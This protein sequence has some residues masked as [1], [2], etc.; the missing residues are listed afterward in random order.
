LKQQATAQQRQSIATVRIDNDLD[1]PVHLE[2][3][4][5]SKAIQLGL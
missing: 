3:Q 4:V 2:Q 1:D 5:R